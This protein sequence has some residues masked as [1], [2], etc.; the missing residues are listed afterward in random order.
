MLTRDQDFTVEEEHGILRCKPKNPNAT[1]TFKVLQL[2][3]QKMIPQLP[4]APDIDIDINGVIGP[5][6]ALGV[7]IIAQRLAEGPHQG[8]AGLIGLQPEE[9]IPSIAENAMEIAGYI[10]QVNGADPTAVVAPKQP[11]PID[12]LA[13]LKGIFTPKRIVAGLG[14]LLGL[15]ALVCFGFAADRRSLGLADRSSMLP[16]S[17]G[18][19]EF[20][21]DAYGGHEDDIDTDNAIDVE[22]TEVTSHAA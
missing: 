17:D 15:G 18:T 10:D 21:E 14:T 22:S 16:P 2:A 5:S 12:P 4:N 1:S 13:Q 19:D 6:I 20:D 3:V 11:E 9:A 7:Q 8:L